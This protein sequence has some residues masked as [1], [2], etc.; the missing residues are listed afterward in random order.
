M[1]KCLPLMALNVL[2]EDNHL[3]VVNKPAGVVTQGAAEGQPSIVDQAKDYL[4]TKYNK[5]GNVYLGIVSRLDKLTTGALVLA[6]TSKAAARLTKAFKDRTVSKTYLALIPPTELPHQGTIENYLRKNDAARRMEVCSPKA[7]NAQQAILHFKLL[8]Q[9][10]QSSQLELNLETGRKHQIR[11]QLAN[12]GTPI[13]GDRKYGSTTSFPH[14][15]ALHSASLT[16]NHPTQKQPM[17]FDAPLPKEWKS[18]IS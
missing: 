1:A 15:I 12:Q 6:R 16:L 9:F 14:G 18:W 3:L 2:Y 5:P 7:D 13:L 17:T 10:S 11:V 8:N 4:R